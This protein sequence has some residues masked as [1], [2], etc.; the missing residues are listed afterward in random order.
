MYPAASKNVYWLALCRKGLP[1]SALKKKK[2]FTAVY[3]G[4]VRECLAA[5]LTP[6]P[7]YL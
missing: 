7:Q 4:P 3:Q 5:V 2:T 1:A 6:I